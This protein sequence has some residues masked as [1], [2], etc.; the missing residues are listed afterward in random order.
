MT[1]SQKTFIFKFFSRKVHVFHVA[2]VWNNLMWVC[3]NQPL[4]LKLLVS[5]HQAVTE[6]FLDLIDPPPS[7]P[8]AFRLWSQV[9]SRHGVINSKNFKLSRFP[10]SSKW[11]IVLW[12]LCEVF[13]HLAS[14]SRNLIF[15]DRKM[16]LKH[17]NRPQKLGSERKKWS[18]VYCLLCT[19]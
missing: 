16:T 19:S 13:P 15:R 3:I 8:H 9:K 17:N 7:L 2:A 18:C 11:L 1:C 6:A 4:L 10:S 14:S 12:K 5:H